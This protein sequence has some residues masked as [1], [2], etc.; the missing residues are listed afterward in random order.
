MAIKVGI[1]GFGRIGRLVYKAMRQFYDQEMHVVA[2]NDVGNVQ[3]MTHLL[4]HDTNYGNFPGEVTAQGN[5]F[6]AGG[7][8]VKVLAAHNP[9]ELPWRKLGVDL[10]VE[11]TGHFRTRDKARLHLDLK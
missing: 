10:M 8:H 7:D 5:G 3:I 11:S 4:K 9:A 6:V 2:V 1:N